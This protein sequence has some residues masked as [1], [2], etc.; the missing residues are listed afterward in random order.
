MGSGRVWTYNSK[1]R[2]GFRFSVFGFLEVSPGL[3][4]PHL[5]FKYFITK[6][7]L[8]PPDAPAGLLDAE[9]ELDALDA[10]LTKLPRNH[11]C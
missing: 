1:K 4:S 3:E 10:S 8:F 2:Q 9:L 11:L 7:S 6:P 5:I